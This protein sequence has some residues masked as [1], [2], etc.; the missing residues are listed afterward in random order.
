MK[1]NILNKNNTKT[2]K[3]SML[4]YKLT[5]VLVYKTTEFGMNMVDIDKSSEHKEE[6][7]KSFI[8][9]LKNFEVGKIFNYKERS[10]EPDNYVREVRFDIRIT[11]EVNEFFTSGNLE[12]ELI[13]FKNSK[14]KENE[15]SF[16]I[17]QILKDM[18]HILG[19]SGNKLSL[20]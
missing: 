13:I 3:C 2:V 7:I 12:P 15:F 6:L 19:I 18:K 5:P 20:N 11:D 4:I 8:L 1:M 10:I 9:P 16:I 17:N 14:L